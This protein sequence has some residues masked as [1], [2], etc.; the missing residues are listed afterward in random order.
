MAT[1]AFVAEGGLVGIVFLMTTDAGFRCFAVARRC[2]AVGTLRDPMAAGQRKLCA[3]VVK[4]RL[5][6]VRVAMTS[7]AVLAKLTLVHIVSLVAGEAG[8]FQFLPVDRSG[9]ALAAR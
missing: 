3:V 9:V 7:C 6:P 4:A 8:S 1:V 2:M 5:L